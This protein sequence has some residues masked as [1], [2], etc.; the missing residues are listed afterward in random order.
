GIGGSAAARERVEMTVAGNDHQVAGG[1]GCFERSWPRQS[2]GRD[3][4]YRSLQEDQAD[5]QDAWIQS[6]ERAEVGWRTWRNRR[7]P[8]QIRNR[9]PSGPIQSIRTEGH[10]ELDERWNSPRRRGR[11][12]TGQQKGLLMDQR[13]AAVG[14]DAGRKPGV[15][16]LNEGDER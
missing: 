15:V 14:D 6:L 11:A 4:P 7:M 16:W 13:A 12:V 8:S 1:L 2:R 5:I 9:S 3:V 10:E